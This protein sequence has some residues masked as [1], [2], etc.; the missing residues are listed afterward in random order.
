MNIE[1]ADADWGDAHREDIERLLNDVA[2]HITRLL[3]DPLIGSIVVEPTPPTKVYPETLPRS[4]PGEP[5]TIL[6]SARGK[7]WAKFSYQFAHEFCH[8]L[9]GYERLRNNPNNWFVEALCEL[10][11]I[12]TLR[13]MAE[14]WPTQPPYPHWASYAASLASY[15][16]SAPVAS[17]DVSLLSDAA[18]QVVSSG[19][20]NLRETSLRKE[21]GVFSQRDRANV[22]VI[23]HALLPLFESEPTGWNAVR[24]VPV[25]NGPLTE[26][27]ADWY[28]QAE[29]TDR[30]FLKRILDAFEVSH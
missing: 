22:A 15:T 14:Q 17:G 30:P 6:L 1:V 25:T 18:K 8:V 28:A 21:F 5:Y 13:R 7:L 12:F 27:L 24:K 11:S 20:D 10:A 4:S 29:L 2:S 16:V 26:Y 3:R 23:S 9:S 19:E